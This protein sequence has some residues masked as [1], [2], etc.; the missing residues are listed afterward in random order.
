MAIPYVLVGN[1]D[2]RFDH[3][4][5]FMDLRL[6]RLLQKNRSSEV[7]NYFV[8]GSRATSFYRLKSCPDSWRD[9]FNPYGSSFRVLPT[10]RQ[11]RW[12]WATRFLLNLVHGR[13]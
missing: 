13:S 10:R 8:N 4:R 5:M 6:V 3:C 7:E 9:W 12:A 11:H 1:P 2:W